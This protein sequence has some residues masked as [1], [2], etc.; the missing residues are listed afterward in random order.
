[1]YIIFNKLRTLLNITKPDTRMC[2]VC[3]FN[4]CNYLEL[5]DFNYLANEA[6][7]I[8]A[9]VNSAANAIPTFAVGS[10]KVAP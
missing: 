3:L 1:M 6:F 10:F 4:Y 5:Q 8:V 9:Y 2:P 7:V